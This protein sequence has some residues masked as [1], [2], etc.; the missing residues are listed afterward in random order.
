MDIV[1]YSGICKNC[2]FKVKNGEW[3]ATT[4]LHFYCATSKDLQILREKGLKIYEEGQ[5]N[6]KSGMGSHFGSRYNGFCLE[7]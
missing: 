6:Q 7:I 4:S 1:R 2:G 3:F 5:R